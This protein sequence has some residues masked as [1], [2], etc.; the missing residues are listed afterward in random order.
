MSAKTK[1]TAIRLPT[2]DARLADEI[3]RTMDPTGT[4]RPGQVL[5]M[6]IKRGLRAL[7]QEQG[8][9]VGRAS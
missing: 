9:K 3:A 5:L 6:S 4:L 1:H 8:L 7:A 2:D